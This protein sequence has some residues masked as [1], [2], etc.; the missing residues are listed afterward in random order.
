M[1]GNESLYGRSKVVLAGARHVQQK[2]GMPPRLAPRGPLANPGRP[3]FMP[4]PDTNRL[5]SYWN[6]E[7]SALLSHA[8]SCFSASSLAMP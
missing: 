6:Q 1:E 3:R 7:S 2:Q 4:L 5:A 8:E